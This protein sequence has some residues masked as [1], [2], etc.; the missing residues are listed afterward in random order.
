MV[1]AYTIDRNLVLVKLTFSQ[2]DQINLQKV[3]MLNGEGAHFFRKY[4][5]S[6]GLKFGLYH[7]LIPEDDP[8]E[9]EIEILG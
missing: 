7:A 9:Y 4:S 3:F 8:F 6:E 5:N 1:V 2:L